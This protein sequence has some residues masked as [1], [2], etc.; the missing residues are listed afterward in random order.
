M[1]DLR[2]LL[3]PPSAAGED[4]GIESL[5]NPIP[6]RLPIDQRDRNEVAADGAPP[7]IDSPE[8]Q[9]AAFTMSSSICMN[10]AKPWSTK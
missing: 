8:R 9:A 5:L 2:S 4:C 1:S 7:D 6:G 10:K 3:N